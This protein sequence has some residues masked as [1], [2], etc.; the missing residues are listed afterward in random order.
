MQWPALSTWESRRPGGR[1]LLV[2]RQGLLGKSV[3]DEHRQVHGAVSWGW[4][5]LH[6]TSIHRHGRSA[7]V[8]TAIEQNM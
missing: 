5:P 7:L 8:T 2:T 1:P 3:D 6:Q 4:R